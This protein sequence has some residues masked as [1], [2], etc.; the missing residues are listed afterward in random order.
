M[1]RANKPSAIGVP[2]AAAQAVVSA[3]GNQVV[4]KLATGESITI[5]LFGATIISW[6]L[7]NGSEQ[8]WLSK[9]AVLDGSQPIR[10]GIPLVFPVFG[11]PPKDRAAVATLPQHGFARSSVWEFLGKTTE[12]ENTVKLDFGLSP[13]MLSEQAKKDW[14]FDFGLVYSVTLT[15]EALRTSLS[16][17]NNGK[18]PFEFQ[19]L[20][21][22]YLKVKNISEVHVRNLEGTTYVDKVH[23][24]AIRTE[25]DTEIAIDKETDRI[26][27]SLDLSRP[28][29]VAAG[30]DKQPV[31]TID[32]ESMSDVVVWNPWI[33]KAK[34][35]ADFGPDDGYKNMLCIEAGAVNGWQNL[36]PGDSWEGGQ[37]I[38]AKL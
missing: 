36:E 6:K 28:V 23:S 9:K 21:H 30:A 34:S 18:Q 7:A 22:T 4:A 2:P 3:E 32:R 38:R 20:L 12:S 17:H 19:A 13:N 16:V 1:E 33:E 11:P 37:T 5:S 8:L 31:F 14:P 26:Y 29:I 25:N 15:P 27:R 35:I 10:G 24:G